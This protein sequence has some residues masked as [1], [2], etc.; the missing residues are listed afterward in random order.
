MTA[1]VAKSVAVPSA[2]K[3]R[4]GNPFSGVR[5]MVSKVSLRTKGFL[6]FASVMTYAVLLA[7]FILYEKAELLKEFGQLQDIY[8]ID[9]PFREV[10][11]AAFHTIMAVYVD[12][13]ATDRK[14]GLQRIQAHFKVLKDKND[15]LTKRFPFASVSFA[16]AERAMARAA[17]NPSETELTALRT[18]LLRIRDE[19]ARLVDQYRQKQ[20]ALAEHFRAQS[21]A[22][23]IASLLVGLFGVVLLGAIIGLFFTRLTHDLHTLRTRALDIIKGERSEP[24]PVDRNDEVGELMEA[25]NFMAGALE[26]REK[27]LVIARQSYFHQE[28]MA[29]V[30]TL[31]AG[32]AHEIGN[33]IAA[34]SGVVQ[35]MVDKQNARECAVTGRACNPGM[36][37]A[38][39]QRLSAITREISGYAAPQPVERQL[40]DLNGLV[41][42]AA[43]LMGYDKRMRRV[44]LRL[45]L[46]SQL[47]AIYGVA[48]QLTQVIMNLL[49][50]AA[51]SLESVED[52]PREI[53]LHSEVSGGNV[54]LTVMDNGC[55]MDR[56]TLNRAFEAFFTTKSRGTGLGL[57]LCYSIVTGHGGTIEIDSTPGMGTQVRIFLPLPVDDEVDTQ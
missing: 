39:I 47:P 20:K 12:A 15:E 51:D 5:H 31:A 35:E 54:R 49:I 45:N 18:E 30:G 44:N 48:D 1:S 42:T 17:A 46:D 38:Q 22:A 16:E 34:M 19:L 57:S 37:Q 8:E 28:K 32:V 9:E 52:R 40:L 27:E 41:R 29:A 4:E 24:I 25:V 7:T 36:L 33:P 43:G 2:P 23:A 10:D 14:A 13:N 6:A 56:D 26:E 11:I 53:T 3:E 55:G 21:D 50:N